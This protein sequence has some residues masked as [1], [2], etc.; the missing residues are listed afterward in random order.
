MRDR[1]PSYTDVNSA[2][3]LENCLYLFYLKMSAACLSQTMTRD[4]QTARGHIY[5][6][7]NF[8]MSGHLVEVHEQYF[9][10]STQ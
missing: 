3:K 6:G 2:E 5:E 10:Y 7:S 1:V 8:R 4:Y 9:C